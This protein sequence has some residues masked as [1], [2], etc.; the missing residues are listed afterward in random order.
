MNPSFLSEIRSRLGSEK[1]LTGA[2]VAERYH[3]IWAMDQALQAKAVILPR[4]TKDVATALKICHEH[5]QPVV[6]HGGLTNLVGSTE[7]HPEEVVIS[8]EKLHA[9]EEVDPQSRTMTVQAGVI[10]E[11]V[12][13]AASEQ[14][15][16]FPLNFGAK[17]SAQMG[18]IIATNAGGLRVFRYGMT[19]QQVLGLE[20]VLADGTVVNSLKKIIKDNSGY[21]LKQL[22][23]GSE[24]TLGVITRAVLKLVEAPRSRSSAWVALADY[25]RVVEFLKF[26]DRGLAGKL[27]AFELMW[28]DTFRAQTQPP[29]RVP[30]P[31]G[32]A[33]SYYVL[34]ESLGSDQVQDSRRLEQLLEEA[35]EQKMIVAAA[36]AHTESDLNWFWA[37]R[38][39]VNVMLHGLPFV[40]QFDIS[41]PIPEIGPL[42]NRVKAQLLAWPEVLK[43]FSFGHV[44]DGNIHLVVGKDSEAE[45]L[46]AR[47]N[48]LVYRPLK[49]IGGSVSAEHGIGLHKKPYLHLCRT[50][51]EIALMR[52]LK[53]TLDPRHIL[54]PGKVIF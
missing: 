7:T 44:A 18:G 17:G 25:E 31:L 14:G 51:A 29:A 15:L 35:L 24:G 11:Q 23:I 37:I 4:N 48:E 27:S 45:E 1:V 22:F 42:V 6:V 12:Q 38:E 47:I 9:I 54:N 20:V 2:A 19:R 53:Q 46:T 8:T 13:N 28:N 33:H 16:L 30:A 34:L 26:M 36:P 32:Y 40:Q 39:Q 10:L 3:H 21:D 50:P 41:L 52:S 5:R 49:D 43:V